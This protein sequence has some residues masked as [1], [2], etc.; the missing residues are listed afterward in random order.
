MS[1]NVGNLDRII[2]VLLGFVLVAL[3][4]ILEGNIRY[5]GLAGVV[6]LFTAVIRWC[7]LYIP[8]KI[9]TK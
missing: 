7:P 5:I 9:K 1:K 4:F 6:F 2:R 3:F 8:F